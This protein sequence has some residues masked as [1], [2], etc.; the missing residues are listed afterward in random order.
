MTAI[1]ARFR[2]Y[3]AERV[4]DRVDRGVREFAE[5]DLPPGGVEIRVGWSSVNYKDGLATR[6][7]GKVARI[8]P[9]IPGIDLA[10]EVVASD[11]AAIAVGG[12][13]LAHGYDLGVSRHGGYSEY[14]RVPTGWV[15][16]L[17]P[18]LSPR[19]AMA[20]GTAGFTAAMS[21]V[22][23][24]ERGLQPDSGPVLVTG[25]SGGVGGTALAI[26]ADRGYEVWAVTGKAD[27]TDRL[28]TLGAAGILSRDEVTAEGRPLESERWAGAVDAV[29]GATL[30]YVLRTLRRGA[31]VA[32]S[33]NAGGA[34]L[35]TTVLPFILRGV[36]LLGMDSV[37]VPIARRRALWDRLATDLRPRDLGIHVTE[38]GLD[39]L[40]GALDGIMAGSARGRW[41]V[42]V[43]G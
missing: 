31:A 28:R 24:E 13:V 30:P 41:V 8:S 10:G 32:A 17:A 20:I 4:G 29:G 15:V 22:A 5:A 6:A 21:V 37:L 11:D 19:E 35:E 39:D 43:G 16:P 27:E 1:P 25:A 36:A 38:V 33:G 3:V 2:A 42:R 40:D 23:L 34:K 14:Q 18:G 26:L 12:A 7:D 9:L